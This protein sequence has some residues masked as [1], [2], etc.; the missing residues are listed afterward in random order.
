VMQDLTQQAVHRPDI[1][2]YLSPRHICI[3]PWPKPSAGKS[4]VSAVR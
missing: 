2:T 3:Y 4:R 1:M